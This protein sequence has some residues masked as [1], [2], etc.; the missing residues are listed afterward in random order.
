MKTPE[1]LGRVE[2]ELLQM[3]DRLQ[4]ASI[5]T[6]V[7]EAAGSSG[8]ARTTIQTMAER[9]RKKGYVT[10]R[11]IG[12]VNHY[13]PRVPVTELLQRLV[14]DF[15]QQTLGGSV[16]PF[17]SYLQG[18]ERVDETELAELKALVRDL[19]SRQPSGQSREGKS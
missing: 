15:V 9:L 5:R 3:I 6:L 11:K 19:E 8:H 12:G 18:V 10:R 13:L 7:D 4:P 17:V 1:P 14:G 16:S 2:L